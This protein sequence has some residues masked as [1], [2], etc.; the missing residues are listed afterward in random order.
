MRVLFVSYVFPPVGGAGV[1]RIT[2]W[3]RYLPEFGITPVV[4]TAA[5]A[6]VPVHD[7]TLE[8][9]I[10][11]HVKILRARTL[12]PDYSTKRRAMGAPR[13]DCV[14]SRVARWAAHAARDLGRLAFPDPQILW[15]PDALG[16]LDAA[17]AEGVD[18]AVITAPPFSSFL[19]LPWIQSRLRIPV[20]LDYRDEWTTTLTS[21][22]DHAAS[23]IVQS[24]SERLEA[25][26]VARADA[27]TTA[28]DEYR[29]ALLSRFPNLHPNRILFLPNGFDSA[30]LPSSPVLPPGDAFVMTYAGTVFRLTSLRGLVDALHLLRARTPRL[31][32]LLQVRIYGRVT[33][34]EEATLAGT[35]SLGIRR[36]G[37]APHTEV[38]AALAAS[39]VN[40]CVLDE[41]PGAERV[42]PAK[43][44]ELMA[45]RRRCLVLT[46][47]GALDRLAR[48]H[49]MGDIVRPR[50][51]T[52][53]AN[54]IEGYLTRWEHGQFPIEH[55]AENID[56]Y[57]RRA[58]AQRLAQV[59]RGLVADEH[60]EAPKMAYP[61]REP[62]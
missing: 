49:A 19:L 7:Q 61:T 34:A 26:L 29:S 60:T 25:W 33:P 44:F 52:G 15:I 58:L 13:H 36:F 22:H 16:R 21:G 56:G 47:P 18:A 28:T 45:L 32:R 17:L 6:S 59:L 1:Q 10:P 54:T 50:D 27:I 9:D 51:A 23:R 31:S 20:V 11:P 30:D 2:K 4:L 14:P 24:L 53:I 12:E 48:S 38:L 8:K 43:A 37:Y 39:H 5:N 42:Y 57:E 55:A 35:E 46:P 40:L 41:V 62:A 3:V